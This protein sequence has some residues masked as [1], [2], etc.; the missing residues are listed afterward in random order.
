L[1]EEMLVGCLITQLMWSL[2]AG[3]RLSGG[4]RNVHHH[5]VCTF[6]AT[7][8][9]PNKAKSRAAGW[10]YQSQVSRRML[11]WHAMDNGMPKNHVMPRL[12]VLNAVFLL[13]SVKREIIQK[14]WP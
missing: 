10:K 1:D 6:L 2:V 13:P 12:Q 5:S 11:G 4:E 7:T 14:T 3:L 8:A 9:H